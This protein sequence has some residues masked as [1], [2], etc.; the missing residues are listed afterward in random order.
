VDAFVSAGTQGANGWYVTRPTITAQS[1]AGSVPPAGAVTYTVDGG[2]PQAYTGPFPGTAEGTT[3]FVLSADGPT[4]SVTVPVDTTLPQIT[5]TTPAAGAS[6]PRSASVAAAYACAETTPSA[7]APSCSATVTPPSGPPVNV[8]SGSALPTA[9]QGGYEML[10]SSTD[11]SGKTAT[12]SRTY[13]VG[14]PT[15]LTGIV[16]TRSNRIWTIGADGSGL[17]Q[18][19]GIPGLDPGSFLDDQAARS[20]DGR[21]IVFARRTSAGGPA[22]LW[23]IDPDGRNP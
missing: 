20:P 5:V 13:T 2:S 21:K 15:A 10:V 18:L 12:L 6:Y 22:Q 7:P 4:R 23:M 17:R 14:T 16:F 1:P 3:D 9:L 8:P 11:Q 19:T